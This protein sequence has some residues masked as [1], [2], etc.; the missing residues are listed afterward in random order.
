MNCRICTEK[1]TQI[2]ATTN[3]NN[4]MQK[5]KAARQGNCSY[6]TRSAH[7]EQTNEI[8]TSTHTKGCWRGGKPRGW[9]SRGYAPKHQPHTKDTLAHTDRG[10][11]NNSGRCP[12][13]KMKE[14][15]PT[16]CGRTQ[17]RIRMSTCVTLQVVSAAARQTATYAPQSATSTNSSWEDGAQHKVSDVGECCE[18]T[19]HAMPPR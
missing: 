5:T 13:G 8:H 18:R 2:H 16:R 4:E 6:R 15:R 12:C 1:Y 19:P 10:F 9:V 7:G 11:C 14:D 17:K 3:I